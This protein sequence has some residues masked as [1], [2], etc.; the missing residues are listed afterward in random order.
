[1]LT[2]QQ[3]IARRKNAQKC[4]KYNEYEVIGLVAYV[5]LSNTGSIMICDSDDWEN[6]KNHCW[7]EN[8]AN[9]YVETTINGRK[10]KYHYHLLQEKSGFVRDHI[11]KNRLDNRRSN[12]RYAS[13]HANSLNTKLSK[14]NKS[15]IKGVRQCKNGKWQSYI[16]IDGKTISLGFYDDKNKATEARK[17]AEEKYHKPIIQK[18]TFIEC[19]S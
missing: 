1:M 10:E 19:F 17:T 12:L 14:A 18:E 2:E 11:N 13:Q 9:G 8:T 3:L 6:Y 4:R 7:H 15:G 16:C 5:K